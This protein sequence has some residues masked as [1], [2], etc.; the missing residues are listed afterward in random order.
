[1][2]NTVLNWLTE[3]PSWLLFA[4]ETQLLGNQLSASAAAN[5]SQVQTIIK[6]V[7]D[8]N[9]GIP[10]LESGELTYTSTG[11]CF[12]GFVFSLRYWA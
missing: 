9:S 10:A 5:D 3:G 2:G 4:A 11:E 6:R 1:M 7:K 12:L 8:F